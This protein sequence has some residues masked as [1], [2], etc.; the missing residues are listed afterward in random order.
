MDES[1]RLSEL[2]H[3]MRNRLTVARAI[4][5]AFIDGKLAPSA[6]RLG[7]VLQSLNQIDELLKDLRANLVVVQSTTR[8]EVIDVCA[9]LTREYQ[10]LEAV[11]ASKGI[12]FTVARCAVPGEACTHF[13][14]DP[15]RIGQIVSNLLLNAVR[16][17]PAGGDIAVDCGRHGGMLK[18]MISDTGRGIAPHEMD[19]AFER[20]YRGSSSEGT[21]GSRYGLTIAKQL[22]ESQGGSV[23]INSSS[24]AGAV[25]TV[26]LPGVVSCAPGSGVRCAGCA[27]FPD[28]GT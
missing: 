11:A 7:S 12:S 24:S 1:E 27:A 20:G 14:G 2:I 17:T 13:V 6:D 21:S 16:Y 23:S 28:E 8:P 19:R 18:V 25:F 22:I 3:D 4:V 10:A 26:K 15:V 9:T 5:E